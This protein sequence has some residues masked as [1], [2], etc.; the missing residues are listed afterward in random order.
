MTYRLSRRSFLAGLGGALGLQILLRNLEAAA[1]GAKS[2]P[3]FLMTFWPNGTARER[4]LPKGGRRDFEISPILEPFENAQLREELIVLYGFA[5]HERSFGAG[6]SQAGTVFATTGADCAGTRRTAGDGHDGAAGGPS[7]DQIFLKRAKGLA[8]P[9]VGY[10]NTLGDARVESYE[11]A[12]QCLS[13]SYDQRSIASAT[14][15]MITEN[16]PLLPTLKPLDAYTQL[17]AGFVPGGTDAAKMLLDLK[18]RKSVLDSALRELARLK[19]LAPAS[20]APKIEAHT[21]AIRELELALQAKIDASTTS[22][23]VCKLPAAPD[24]NLVGKTGSAWEYSNPRVTEG[25]NDWLAEVTNQHLLLIRTAFQCDLI[26][27]ATFQPC[28]ATNRIRLK[29]MNPGDPEAAYI[30]HPYVS[31]LPVWNTPPAAGTEESNIYEFGC[32]AQRWFYQNMADALVEFRNTKDAFGG[33]L[34]DHTV[35]TFVTDTTSPADGWQPMP[36]LIVG[37]RALGMLGGQCVDLSILEAGL[38]P[39]NAMWLSVAQ[40]YF[41]D[42]DPM[43]VLADETFMKIAVPATGP[44]AGL[45][46]RPA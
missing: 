8:R 35:T 40:A 12:S 28:P 19:T 24:A 45:W 7:F 42:E 33:T 43:K 9:G 25:D 2:P 41:P 10:I 17:F 15:G 6:S 30:H 22:A 21:A 3:R 27:V 46:Q 32:N 31:A 14:S 4:F 5:F 38:P 20:Q 29:G 34:L 11:I 39:H 1:E 13:Y 37:G 36:A 16:I 26:R 44:I 18:K 23:G